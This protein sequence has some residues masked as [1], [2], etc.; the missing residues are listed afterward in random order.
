M[1]GP[2]GFNELLVIFLIILLVFGGAKLPELARSIGKAMR[3]FKKG[4][5]ELEEEKEKLFSEEE[6]KEE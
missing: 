5:Q 3:E 1:F 6:S 2:L 4:M